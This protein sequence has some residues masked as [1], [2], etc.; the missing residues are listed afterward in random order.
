MEYITISKD[1]YNNI[2]RQ[3][4]EDGEDFFGHNKMKTII[5]CGDQYNILKLS[6]PKEKKALVKMWNLRY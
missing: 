4:D 5:S 2:K 1:H 6:N 3:L